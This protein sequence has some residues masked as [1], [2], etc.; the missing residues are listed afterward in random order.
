M[1]ATDTEV[2]PPGLLSLLR[3]A[4]LTGIGALHNRGELFLVELQEEKNRSIELFIWIAAVCF[5]GIMFMGVLTAT[6][7]LLVPE[8]S[9]VYA[10]GG[11]ALFYLV[12]AVLAF[13]NLKALVKSSA[14]PFS[15]TIDEVKRDRAWL[16]SLK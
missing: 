4:A 9:R 8:D 10:A 1:A 2:H 5:A 6:V 14:S 7:I 13:L 11:F 12:V 16:D 3:K 15:S